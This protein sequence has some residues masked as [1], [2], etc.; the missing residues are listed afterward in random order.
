MVLDHL[1]EQQPLYI[2]PQASL[3][4]LQ[5]ANAAEESAR[6]GT[7]INMSSTSLKN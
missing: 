1:F 6:T 2:R 4:A 3:Y 7:L 5:V